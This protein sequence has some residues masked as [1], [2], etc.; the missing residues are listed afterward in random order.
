VPRAAGR[1]AGPLGQE[2]LDPAVFEGVEGHD[3]E[4]PAGPED[5]LGG[6]KP[7]VKFGQLIIHRDPQGLE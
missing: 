2:G 7:G 5:A 1:A 3:G 6:H 4:A